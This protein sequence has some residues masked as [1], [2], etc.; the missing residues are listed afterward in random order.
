M[1]KYSIV[2]I[3]AVALKMSLYSSTVRI[4]THPPFKILSMILRN[5][6]SGAACWT[7]LITCRRY[8]RTLWRL[9]LLFLKMLNFFFIIWTM[10]SLYG[11]LSNFLS[12]IHSVPSPREERQSQ[13]DLPLMFS[14]LDQTKTAQN[15]AIKGQRIVR[16]ENR[17][18]HIMHKIYNSNGTYRSQR[19]AYIYIYTYK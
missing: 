3:H 16:T 13:T 2:F 9:W 1:H 7:N 12:G 6:W 5:V 17:P 14:K 4:Y 11:H 8:V 18:F 15:Y 19:A 10:L